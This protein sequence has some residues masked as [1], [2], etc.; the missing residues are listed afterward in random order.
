MINMLLSRRGRQWRWLLIGSAAMVCAACSSSGSSSSG[1]T[2]ATGS[3]AAAS[4]SSSSIPIMGEGVFNSP[5]VS[6]PD[7]EA[8]MKAAVDSINAK[9]GINGHKIDLATM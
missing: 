9:G 6:L 2:A 8:A 5:N 1:S 3:S 7:A 4:G